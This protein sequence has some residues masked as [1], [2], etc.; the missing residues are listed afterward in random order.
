[1]T[2]KKTAHGRAVAGTTERDAKFA[3]TYGFGKL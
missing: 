1:M 2:N 3:G